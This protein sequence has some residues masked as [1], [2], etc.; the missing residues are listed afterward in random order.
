MTAPGTIAQAIRR[1]FRSAVFRDCNFP[2]GLG[3]AVGL[4]NET[5]HS[6]HWDGMQRGGSPDHPL[7]TVQ[8]T[9]AGW[10]LFQTGPADDTNPPLRVDPGHAFVCLIPS[11]H[12]YWLPVSSTG[13]DHVW[14][15]FHHPY[16]CQRMAEALA[17]SHPV[18]T[19]S[20]DD[21]F[22]GAFLRLLKGVT[23]GRFRDR[24]R[25][26]HALV[27]LAL[28]FSSSSQDT[29]RPPDEKERL[30]DQIFTFLAEHPGESLTVDRLANACGWSRG[31]YTARFRAVTGLTPAQAIAHQ[32]TEL[33]RQLILTSTDPIAV[34]AARCGFADASHFSKVFRR[35]LGVSPR[36]LRGDR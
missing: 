21:W 20:D 31:H 25:L 29:R 35:F 8:L 13:W 36:H 12:R 17:K 11:E 2:D 14:C 3:C 4:G 23:D 30:L 22:L 15:C 32:R 33:A 16:A 26:E 7:I 27:E 6:Y 10:G 28:A 19:A 24:H 34:V 18:V 1:M 9:L 5:A